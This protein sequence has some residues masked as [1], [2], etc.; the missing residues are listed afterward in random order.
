M[1]SKPDTKVNSKRDTKDQAPHSGAFAPIR[2]SGDFLRDQRC[3]AKL[4][5]RKLAKLAGVSNPYLS[6]VERGLRRPSQKVVAQVTQ[7]IATVMRTSSSA[8]HAQAERVA[9]E[10]EPAKKPEVLN[11]IFRDP[12]LTD[13]QRKEL[14]EHYETL[15]IE[16]AE[17]RARRSR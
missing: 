7:A 6:Q 17:R 11:S 16:T 12:G 4:S 1:N 5:V 3:R 14:A 9:P 10:S 13:G 8:L 2:L 15:R